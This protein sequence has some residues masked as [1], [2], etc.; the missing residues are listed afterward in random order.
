MQ[1]FFAHLK[2]F[3][4]FHDHVGKGL[5]GRQILIEVLLIWLPGGVFLL[6][7]SVIEGDSPSR[8]QI[9][10]LFPKQSSSLLFSVPTQMLSRSQPVSFPNEN[11]DH[12]FKLF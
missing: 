10:A 11:N 8:S 4:T 12:T 1:A 7:D 9:Q 6:D 3:V 5:S 2:E